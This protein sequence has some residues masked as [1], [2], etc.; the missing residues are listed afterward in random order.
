LNSSRY[1]W[2]GR[3]IVRTEINSLATLSFEHGAAFRT[4]AWVTYEWPV[5]L[6]LA[7]IYGNDFRY[8]LAALLYKNSVV[9]LEVKPGYLICVMECSPLN[10]RAGQ[11]HR[12]EISN[13]CHCA[14]SAHLIGYASKLRLDFLG[15]VFIRNCPS[16]RFGSKPKIL[17]L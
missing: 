16:G 1:L 11:Q 8:N 4:K 17:L 14:S 10:N 3:E 12:F 9:F 15:F 2:G 7:K 13:R 6:S 5:C